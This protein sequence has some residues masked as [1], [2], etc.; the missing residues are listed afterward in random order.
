MRDRGY[1]ESFGGSGFLWL[2][3]FVVALRV[4]VFVATIILRIFR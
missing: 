3:G 1:G 2:L 4:I